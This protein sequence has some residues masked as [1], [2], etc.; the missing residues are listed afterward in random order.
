M[1]TAEARA[2]RSNL[3]DLWD[4]EGAHREEHLVHTDPYTALVVNSLV[5]LEK[6]RVVHAVGLDL[7]LKLFMMFRTI[8]ILT[9][10]EL[11]RES[12]D[13]GSGTISDS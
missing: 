12:G 4:T 6:A 2:L 9:S 7:S 10:P 1:A 3:D 11:K 5:Q 13:R 8:Q